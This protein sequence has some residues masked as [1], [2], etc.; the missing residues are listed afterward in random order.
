MENTN[1]PTPKRYAHVLGGTYACWNLAGTYPHRLE[2][3][4]AGALGDP[5][6]A[7]VEPKIA[8]LGG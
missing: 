4:S 1:M 5:L 7:G 2:N 3:Q 8:V 6:T